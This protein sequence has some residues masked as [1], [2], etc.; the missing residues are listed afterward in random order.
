MSMRESELKLVE[1]KG[2]WEEQIRFRADLAIGKLYLED[3]AFTFLFHDP[4][5]HKQHSCA[6]HQGSCN[7]NGLVDMFAYRM[8]FP[9]ANPESGQLGAAEWPFHHNYILGNDPSKWAGEVKIYNQASYLGLYPGID[10]VLKGV[11]DN[12]KY[13]VF[14]EAGADPA[15]FKVVYDGIENL[16]IR[17]GRLQYSTPFADIEELEPYAYQIINGQKEEVKCRYKLNGSELSFE[18]PQGYNRSYDLVIDPTLVF[19][20][21]SGSTGDNFGYTATYD[22][23]G[24]LYAGSI[25][26]EPG[27]PTTTGAYQTGFAGAN[28]NGNGIQGDMAISKFD[29]A[30]TTLLY[31]TYIGGFDNDQP[32]SMVVNAN[33]ELY[34]YGR[35]FSSNFPT[36]IGSFDNTWNGSADI[37][38]CR[39]SANGSILLN[40][41]FVGGS[42]RDGI[43]ITENA[44]STSSLKFNYADDARGEIILDNNGNVLVASCTQSQ[45]FPTTLNAPQ[46]TPGGGQDGCAF[47]LDPTLTN[48]DWSTLIGGSAADAAYSIK[49]D[50]LGNVFICGGTV[51]SNLPMSGIPY[52]GTFAGGRADGFII[53]IN[54]LGTAF[55]AATYNGTPD[56]D[57]NYFLE[58]DEDNEVYV[59]GQTAGSYP[60]SA[61]VYVNNNSS[62]FIHKFDNNLSQTILSTVVGSGSSRPNISPTAFLVDKCDNIYI[63]GWG[64]NVNQGVNSQ[65]GT[66]NGM[67]TTPDAFKSNTDGN[68]FY[69]LVLEKDMVGLLFASHYGGNSSITSG[70]HVDGGTSRFD[71][72]GVIYQAI[73]AGCGGNSFFPTTQGVWSPTNRSSN[74]NLG[75]LKIEFDL[76]GT[77]V[78]LNAVPTVTGCVPLRVSFQ[79]TLRKVNQVIWHFGDGNTSTQLNPTH[80]YTDTGTFQVMLIGID[81][82]SCNI[83]DTAF[84]T[85]TVRDDSV[86]ARFLD[87]TSVDCSTRTVSFATATNSNNPSFSWDFGD[88]NTSFL[89]TPSHTYAQPGTYT[90]TLRVV[91]NSSC[92]IQ[93]VKTATVTIPDFALLDITLSD[94]IGC[95]PLPVSLLNNTNSPFGTFNWD[96]GDGTVSQLRSPSHTFTSAGVFPVTVTLTDSNSCNINDTFSTTVT[97]LDSHAVADFDVQRTFY[98]C[99]SMRLDVWSLF[100]GAD[101]HYW[102]FGDG[103]IIID[104]ATSH[105]YL[106]GQYTLH[107]IVT[108]T[109]MICRPRDTA[110][111]DINVIPVQAAFVPSDTGGCIPLG[112]RFNNVTNIPAANYFWDFGDGGF[113]TDSTPFHTFTTVDSFVVTLAVTD[114]SICNYADTF[115]SVIKTRDDFVLAAFGTNILQD[116][117]SVLEV[118]FINQSQFATEYFWDFGDGSTSTATNPNHIYTVPGT[119]QVRL[120]VQDTNRCHP[121]DTAFASLRLKPNTRFDFDI[122]DVVC[123]NDLVQVVNNGSPTGQFTWD[124]GDGT[125]VSGFAPSHRYTQEGTY[126]ITVYLE[127]TATCNVFDTAGRIIQVYSHPISRFSTDTNYYEWEE[128]VQFYNESSNYDDLTWY[129]GDGDSSNT[130]GDPIHQY[131]V[132]GDVRPCIVTFNSPARC[133]DTFC[134][135]LEI[136]FEA[137]LGVP[138]A[139]SPN[140]DGV[141]DVHFVEGKGITFMDIKIFNR[142]G[143][144]VFRSTDQKIG[145]DGRFN[146]KPQ[147]MEVYVYSINVEF[148][149]GTTMNK[150]GNITLLR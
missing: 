127:D 6:T 95:Y 101:I 115:R 53:K 104:S 85:I 49:P 102:D 126:A 54:N 117:D 136:W 12:L 124:F 11:G 28:P 16:Q 21:Y 9:G 100:P 40:S 33:D 64:G 112:V 27:Y 142:W 134:I 58:I 109:S 59:Y 139:F 46:R 75:A 107:Y 91:D 80:I 47:R 4:L 30:G 86:S 69:F 98:G 68:D 146:G 147:E 77:D 92:N 31:S 132:L 57:Q 65:A 25:A 108:D 114:S 135:D 41:T 106:P 110:E 2:Q 119:Y 103:T 113:S 73:C 63:S 19:S 129:F 26:L 8:T 84:E 3:T 138:N 125:V 118:D 42:G 38:I 22:A 140:G 123:D 61:G 145:W 44:V 20:S 130:T 23:A 18:F 17:K 15:Q 1:N 148:V 131:Y 122:I 82:S 137:A 10:L 55:L 94:T 128:Q 90:V 39:L 13:D 62:Q 149:D 87:L 70:E 88:G 67:P 71:R 36:T 29:A 66:T 35:S 120:I 105:T 34:V 93:D 74:C 14:V 133:S 111:L 116:C 141:N 143:Q 76:S 99:D 50:A 96:F 5:Y 144:L 83:A 81:S 56:Y 32:Q 52:Q 60:V 97:V 150:S 45:N 7:A 121:L 48:M 51:S 43:N 24:N 79:S 89:A 72:E 37:V 78:D